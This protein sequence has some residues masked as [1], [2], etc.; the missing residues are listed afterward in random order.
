MADPEQYDVIIIGAGISGMYMSYR[1]RELDLSCRVYEAGE[2]LGGTWFWNRYPGCR[3]D[4]ESYSYGYSVFPEVLEEWDWSEQFA[5]QPETLE[6]LNFIADKYDLR[7]DITFNARVKSATY[8]ET[9]NQ[10]EVGFEDGSKARCRLLISATGPLSA[11]TMPA[12]EGVDD[13]KGVSHHTAEW[14]RDLNG[15]G[16]PLNDFSGKRVGVIG[17]G[18]TGVQVI[19]EVSKSADQLY[20]FSAHRTGARRC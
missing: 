12:I 4:S 8:D 20:V 16:S 15:F 19:Q 6:Y 9:D 17:T 7:R 11:P 3:F 18:A 1:L 5:A 2:D 13:F 10:W 14:P